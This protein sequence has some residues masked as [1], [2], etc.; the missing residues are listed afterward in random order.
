MGIAQ[1][2]DQLRSGEVSARELTDQHLKQIDE[3]E[4]TKDADLLGR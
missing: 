2:R 4:K 1:W 3:M